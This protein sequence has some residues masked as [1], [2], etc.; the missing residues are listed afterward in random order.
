MQKLL[1]VVAIV[2]FCV[3]GVFATIVSRWANHHRSFRSRDVSVSISESDT[4]YQLRAYYNQR[5]TARVERCIE[6]HLR[7]GHVFTHARMNADL[8]LDDAT[9]LYVKS[10]PGSLLIR[11]N[12]DE[13]SFEAYRRIKLLG[14]DIK[15]EVTDH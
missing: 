10:K 3:I 9:R 13:N 6:Q 5:N 8:V 1:L 14:T 2:A 7:A 11:F 15:Y 4:R 12:K